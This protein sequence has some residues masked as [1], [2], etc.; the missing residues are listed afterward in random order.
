MKIRHLRNATAL[1]TLAEHRLLVDPMLADPGSFPGFKL[2]GGGRRPNPLVPLP[3][4]ASDALAEATGA[5]IT[6]EHPDHLDRAGIRWIAARGLPVWASPVDAPSLRR[7]GLD[8]R[9]LVDGALDMTV[10]LVPARHGRGVLAWLMGPVSGF[11]LAHPDEPSVYFTSD[12]VL[13]DDLLRAVDRLRPDVLVA[14]AGAANMGA[15]GDILFSLDELVTL[16]RRAPG[17]VLLNHLEALDHCPTTRASLLERMRTEG[18]ADKVL[19]PDDGQELRFD[20]PSSAPRPRPQSGAR[21]R[22]GVQKWVT[23]WFTMT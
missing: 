14:P 18:L 19:V 7:K 8:V 16:V 2:F 20:R 5:I 11:Y 23:S 1:L 4:A 9:E 21:P 10:E 3:P 22:P 13:T 17:R 6:H 15:G 12:A